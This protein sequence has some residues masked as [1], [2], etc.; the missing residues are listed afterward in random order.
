MF[1]S[2]RN[3]NFLVLLIVLVV[4]ILYIYASVQDTRQFID[5]LFVIFFPYFLSGIVTKKQKYY[6][7]DMNKFLATK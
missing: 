7:N 5:F 4:L 1:S 2:L 3:D 6:K